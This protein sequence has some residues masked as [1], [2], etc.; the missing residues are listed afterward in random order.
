[1]GA[2][3]GIIHGAANVVPC[4]SFNG[5]ACVE[6]LEAERCTSIYGTPTMF[7]DILAAARIRKPDVSHVETG[8]MAGEEIKN[9]FILPARKIFVHLACPGAPC[10]QELCKNIMSELNMRNFVV[11]YGM[12]ETSPV[13]FQGFI[14]DPLEVRTSTVGFPSNHQEVAVMDSAGRIVEAGVEGELVT[15]GYST[16][17]GYWADPERTAEVRDTTIRILL[18]NI[19]YSILINILCALGS[20]SGP[21]APHRRHSRHRPERL[22]EDRG[23]DEGRRSSLWQ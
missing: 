21:V 13:T 4:P 9:I 20:G 3:C 16:M 15:R 1:M 8:I 6:A 5:A 12:T 17:L 22:R 7:I 19:I 10:P 23:E 11:C 14:S 18:Y 2:L